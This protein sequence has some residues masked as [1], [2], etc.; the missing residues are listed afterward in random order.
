[1]ERGWGLVHW[2]MILISHGKVT[3][4]IDCVIFGC[5]SL[6][7]LLWH[8]SRVGESASHRVLV[9][10]GAGAGS[11]LQNPAPGQAE[12]IDRVWVAFIDFVSVAGATRAEVV[13]QGP[14]LLPVATSA[15]RA[16]TSPLAGQGGVG[17]VRRHRPPRRHAAVG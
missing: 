14:I 8:L 4:L 7:F 1:M 15:L 6:L 2:E 13:T 10:I 16:L 17:N 9:S 12:R 3:I 5:S 11:I